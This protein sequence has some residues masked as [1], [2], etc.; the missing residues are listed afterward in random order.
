MTFAAD[1]DGATPFGKTRANTSVLENRNQ[2]EQENCKKRN[3]ERE[4]KNT[5]IDAN[6]GDASALGV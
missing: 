6:L 4:E 5:R 2:P 3:A 1:P